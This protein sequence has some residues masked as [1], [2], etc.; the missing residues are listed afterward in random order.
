MQHKHQCLHMCQGQRCRI[1]LGEAA[2]VAVEVKIKKKTHS[3]SPTNTEKP[4]VKKI[5]QKLPKYVLS[6]LQPLKVV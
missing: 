5:G 1:K 2:T 3:L 4:V 6:S